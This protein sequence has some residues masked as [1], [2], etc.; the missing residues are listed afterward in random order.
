MPAPLG[1]RGLTQL[2][3]GLFHTM[4]EAHDRI[5]V[6]KAQFART[7]PIPTLGVRTTEFDLPRPRA[8]ELYDSGR[9][10]AEKFLST[11]DFDAYKAEF[12]SGKKQSRS[13][14]L[15]TLYRAKGAS[16]V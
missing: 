6:E 7:I 4:V 2:F 9:G 5:Y 16:V 3:S 12:R 1:A 11:W 10:A 14:D 13:A 8:Q 15:A